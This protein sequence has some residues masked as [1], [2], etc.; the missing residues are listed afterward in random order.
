MA[1]MIKN[2]KNCP[3]EN[4][5]VAGTRSFSRKTYFEFQNLKSKT[6]IGHF[7]NIQILNGSKSQMSIYQMGQISKIQFSN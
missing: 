1:K 2:G 4:D 5:M 3:K 7:S 6:Q